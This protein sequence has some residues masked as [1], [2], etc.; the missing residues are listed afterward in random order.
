MISSGYNQFTNLIDFGYF[1][2][3]DYKLAVT[4]RLILSIL[5]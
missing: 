1:R 5:K 2:M 4:H 3:A